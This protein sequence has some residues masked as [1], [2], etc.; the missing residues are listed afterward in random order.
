MGNPNFYRPQWQKEVSVP[1]TTEK[2]P[3]QGPPPPITRG[4]V[5]GGLV[6][7]DLRRIGYTFTRAAA[8]EYIAL[9][10]MTAERFAKWQAV[11]HVEAWAWGTRTPCP[12]QPWDIRAAILAHVRGEMEE[13]ETT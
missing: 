13:E 11:A 9:Y 4:T 12:F 10:Q 1:D 3:T 7:A 6:L 2:P 5:G 8:L